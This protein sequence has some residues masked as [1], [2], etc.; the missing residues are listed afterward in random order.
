MSMHQSIH[1]IYGLKLDFNALNEYQRELFYE[2]AFDNLD[3]MFDVESGNNVAYVGKMLFYT[4]FNDYFIG[5]QLLERIGIPERIRI[6]QEIRRQ[7]EIDE[8]IYLNTY[9]VGTYG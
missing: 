6:N 3:S 4:S 8:N 7:L 2:E 9:I 5:E 1:I